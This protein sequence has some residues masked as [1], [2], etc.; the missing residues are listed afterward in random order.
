M[1]NHFLFTVVLVIGIVGICS[2]ATVPYSTDF[3]TDP[4]WV[5]DQPSNYYWNSTAGSYYIHNTNTYPDYYPNRYAGKTMSQP[6]DS[7]ELRWDVNVT[8]CDWS[9]GLYFGVWDSSL[10]ETSQGG[11]FIFAVIGR[12]DGGHCISFD[13]AANGIGAEAGTYPGWSLNEWYTFKIS[14]D[15][16]TK[17]A[18]LE[19][20]DRDT[21]QSIWSSTLAVPGGGFTKN[22][23]FLGSNLGMVGSHGYSG[24]DRNAVLEANLDN[25]QVIPEPA[26][27]LLLTLGGIILRKKR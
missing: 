8:R 24:I 26:T 14:Y 20:L 19:V 16:D 6:V 27:I 9:S 21:A 2:A 4:G 5:T 1:R 11:E 18:A 22:L 17:I 13:V 3:S 15:S 23:Q 10:Q 12:A 7:F 25:V